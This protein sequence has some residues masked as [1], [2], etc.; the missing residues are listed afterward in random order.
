MEKT[1]DNRSVELFAKFEVMLIL[2]DRI[3]GRLLLQLVVLPYLA[4]AIRQH[5]AANQ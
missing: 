2:F 5:F 3:S 1:H 4:E